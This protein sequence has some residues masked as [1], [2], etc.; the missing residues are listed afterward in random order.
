MSRGPKMSRPRVNR[1]ECLRISGLFVQNSECNY[2]LNLAHFCA[3]NLAHKTDIFA[4][5]SAQRPRSLCLSASASKRRISHCARF[6]RNL[7]LFSDRAQASGCNGLIAS[8][9]QKRRY[10]VDANAATPNPRR[11]IL[12][13][14]L[15][16]LPRVV[17]PSRQLIFL[18][19]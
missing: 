11:K 19:L 5:N 18:M 4:S 9:P 16:R 1:E 17:A 12:H 10:P 15:P 6:Y 3:E 7:R 8:E 2:T 13:P 14:E